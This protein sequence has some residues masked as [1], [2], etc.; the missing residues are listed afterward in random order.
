MSDFATVYSKILLSPLSGGRRLQ[1][2]SQQ[3]HQL[4]PVTSAAFAFNPSTSYSG[5]TPVKLFAT[6]RMS[7]T[8]PS[9]ESQPQTP[10]FQQ[11]QTPLRQQHQQLR[12]NSAMLQQIAPLPSAD[13]RMQTGQVLK[14]IQDLQLCTV[15]FFFPPL[16]VLIACLCSV[17]KAA[18]SR[19]RV[20]VVGV[21]SVSIVVCSCVVHPSPCNDD[22]E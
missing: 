17:G 20:D 9:L 1:A 14:R 6:P 15:P 11:L 7:V 3:Q 13:E 16:V 4:K 2:Q 18:V 8:K 10:T 22:Q 5:Y 19:L 12:Q 21:A